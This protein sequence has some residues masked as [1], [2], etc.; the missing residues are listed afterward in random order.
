MSDNQENEVKDAQHY[1]HSLGAM[2]VQPAVAHELWNYMFPAEGLVSNMTLFLDGVKAD[3]PE[4]RVELYVNG[5]FI[6]AVPVKEGENNWNEGDPQPVVR[7]D[8]VALNLISA[9]GGARIGGAYVMF[10]FHG[11]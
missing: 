7:G 4:L 6:R 9:N 2:A 1:S 5:T 3:A 11:V 8:K 10:D